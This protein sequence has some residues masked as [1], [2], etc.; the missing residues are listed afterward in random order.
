LEDINE[1]PGIW[2][3]K[4]YGELDFM[5]KKQYKGRYGAYFE[6][7]S[8]EQNTLHICPAQCS[9]GKPG[10]RLWVRE[11][12]AR[13]QNDPDIEGLKDYFPVIYKASYEDPDDF[14][15][16][17]KPSIHMPRAASRLTLEI[18]E[19]RVERLQ[20][21]STEDSIAEGLIKLPASGRYV[22]QKGEQY[23]GLASNDP[24]EVFA[25]L[26]DSINAKKHPWD[27]NPWVWVISFRRVEA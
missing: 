15:G 12:W 21:I 24:R 11:T 18:T 19:V 23:A 9:F 2:N 7:K 20:D 3:F 4:R 10:D 17:W 8:I 6:T 25:R 13:Y 26:W 27:S 1:N 22:L 5:T 14:E 16:P